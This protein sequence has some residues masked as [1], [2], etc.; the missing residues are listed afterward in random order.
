MQYETVCSELVSSLVPQTP[1]RRIVVFARAPEPG[2]VK[3]RLAAAIGDGAAL[4]IYR[5]LLEHTLAVVR[6]N[7]DCEVEVRFTPTGAAELMEQCVGGALPLDRLRPQS[8]GDL[9]TRMRLAIAEALF[10]GTTHVV[11]VGT[12][13]PTL[14]APTIE[15]AFEALGRSDVVLGPAFD[16]GYYL[17]ATSADHPALFENIPWSSTETL[18]RTLDAATSAGLTVTLLRTMSDIDTADDWSRY[19][20]TSP[21]SHVPPSRGR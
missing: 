17:I 5:W 8:D 18:A 21:A 12:D 15:A 2:R 13:C 20:A 14:D 9:G 11:V 10:E 4:E 19:L 6:T 7:P 1:R 16:G 3:T